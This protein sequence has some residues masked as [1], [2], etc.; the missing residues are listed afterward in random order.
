M[1]LPLVVA[2]LEQNRRT[3]LLRSC[4]ERRVPFT[5]VPPWQQLLAVMLFVLCTVWLLNQ[6]AVLC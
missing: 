3:L 5:A 1:L 4:C 6:A 2:A